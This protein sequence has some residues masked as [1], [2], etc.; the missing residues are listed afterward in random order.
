MR[1]NKVDTVQN[2]VIKSH[3]HHV[4]SDLQHSV[5][6]KGHVRS[7]KHSAKLSVLVYIHTVRNK[8]SNC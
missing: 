8:T 5:H 6:V 3:S 2:N 4:L 1:Q 7:E